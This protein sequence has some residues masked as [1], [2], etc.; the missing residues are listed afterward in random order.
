MHRDGYCWVKIDQNN[1]DCPEE[2]SFHVEEDTGD[3]KTAKKKQKNNNDGYESNSP[4]LLIKE[5]VRTLGE[6][7]ATSSSSSSSATTPS[8]SALPTTTKGC[9][10]EFEKLKALDGFLGAD[11][12]NDLKKS[13][14]LHYKKLMKQEE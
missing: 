3:E 6:N 5:L 12:L 7:N 2:H 13:L 4:S 8:S 11:E 1:E 14:L 10:E 9:L